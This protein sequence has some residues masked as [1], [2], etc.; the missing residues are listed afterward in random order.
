[1]EGKI[2]KFNEMLEKLK[3]HGKSNTIPK[4]QF[5]KQMELMNESVDKTREEYLIMEANAKIK[6]AGIIIR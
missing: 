1:M 3:K 4:E 2:D 6:A 5:A